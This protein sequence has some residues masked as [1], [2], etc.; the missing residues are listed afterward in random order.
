MRENM[1]SRYLR[2]SFQEF[3]LIYI[4]LQDISHIFLMD[5][6]KKKTIKYKQI[7][8]VS[9]LWH[10]HT[11]ASHIEYAILFSVESYCVLFMF[12]FLSI[13]VNRAVVSA[14]VIHHQIKL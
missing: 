9:L 5:S 7:F 10:S 12:R 2:K 4:F 8:V 14:V 13:W 11:F 6:T 3:N 1:R